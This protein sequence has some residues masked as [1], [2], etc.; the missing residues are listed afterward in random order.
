MQPV[1]SPE[2]LRSTVE[3]VVCVFT[4]LSAVCSYLLAARA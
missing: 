3:M 4:L 2:V 1:I